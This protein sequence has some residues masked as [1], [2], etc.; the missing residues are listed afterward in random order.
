M[1]PAFAQ[2]FVAAGCP[3]QIEYEGALYHVFSRGNKQQNI[4]LTDDDRYLFLNIASKV[5]QSD[6]KKSKIAQGLVNP[7]S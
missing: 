2:G 6:L 4:F 7:K 1:A 5:L 3:W